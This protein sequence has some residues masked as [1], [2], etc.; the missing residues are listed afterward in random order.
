MTDKTFFND[1][2]DIANKKFHENPSDESDLDASDGQTY[3]TNGLECHTE[4]SVCKEC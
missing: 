4:P 3:M 1:F 2:L